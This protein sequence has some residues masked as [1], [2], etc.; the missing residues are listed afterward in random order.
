MKRLL[1]SV[2]AL[3]DL[4]WLV[5]FFENHADMAQVEEICK[6][7]KLARVKAQSLLDGQELS[8]IIYLRRPQAIDSE[9]VFSMSRDPD[10]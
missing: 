2:G 4:E 6:A 1:D 8:N 10:V 7:V 3:D 9:E 5:D